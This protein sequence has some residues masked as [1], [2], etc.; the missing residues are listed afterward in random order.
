MIDRAQLT[1]RGWPRPYVGVSTG[2]VDLPVPWVSPRNELKQTDPG[3][4]AATI[5][6]L[7]CQVCGIGHMPGETVIMF[8]NQETVP[9]DLSNMVVQ[10]MDDAVLHENCA[11]LTLGRCPGVRAVIAEGKLHVVRT[12]S[13]HVDIMFPDEEPETPH[14]CAD[15]AKVEVLSYEDFK[16]GGRG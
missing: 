12:F 7:L 3:R 9:E 11:R 13:D 15:G 4:H 14:L 1:D 6:G 5:H 16:M 8:V 10:A 2:R